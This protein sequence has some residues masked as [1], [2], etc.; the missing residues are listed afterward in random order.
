MADQRIRV[1]LVFGGQSA[2]HDISRVSAAN[3]AAALDPSRYDVVP[4][5]IRRDGSWTLAKAAADLLD[6]GAL[7]ELAPGPGAQRTPASGGLP[8]DGPVVD[9]LPAIRGLAAPGHPGAE[10][11]Q[12]VVALPVLHGP[13]GEDGTI[14]GMFELAGI[15]YVGSGVLASALA[16]DKSAAKE[17]AAA[18]GLPQARFRS[19]RESSL[20]GDRAGALLDGIASDLG[21]PLFVKPANMGSSVGVSKVPDRPSLDAAVAAALDY[22]E[23]VVFE[24][25]ITGR[26][27]ELAVLGL[28][29]DLRISVPGEVVPGADFYDY[30]D[31]YSDGTAE[32]LIPAPL[33]DEEVAEAQDLVRRACHA[34]RIEVMARVDLFYEERGRGFL[35]NEINTI[36]GCTPISMFPALWAATGLPYPALLDE[37]IRL[38]LLRHRRRASRRR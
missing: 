37:M 29:D 18:H 23:T 13:N 34:M 16:M 22:D 15:P 8:T 5:G 2:E 38:S 28:D 3:V 25:A 30:D 33:S 17:M 12:Q 36:P 24:E 32:L 1:V 20:T 7:G 21:L 9:P 4:V 27:I 31:K 6:A 19:A 14:Q 11:G 26:E 10:A 35:L